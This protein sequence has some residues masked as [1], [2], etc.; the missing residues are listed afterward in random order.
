[1]SEESLAVKGKVRLIRF[2]ANIFQEPLVAVDYLGRPNLPMAWHR[3]VLEEKDVG[4]CW[5]TYLQICRFDHEVDEGP[6]GLA[7]VYS[8]SQAVYKRIGIFSYWDYDDPTLV[9]QEGPLAEWVL[10]YELKEI[11]VI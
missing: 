2:S 9:E 3:D 1:V 10:G 5:R 11:T 8:P 4:L 7:L 6:C